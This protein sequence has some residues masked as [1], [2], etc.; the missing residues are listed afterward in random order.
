[1]ISFR[2]HIVTIV[3]VFLALAIGLLGGAAFVQPA[4]QEQLQDQTDL[5]R[6]DLANR[7]QQIE[8]LREQVAA[9]NGFAESVMPYLTSGALTGTPVVVVTQTGVEDEVLAQA[10]TALASA[11]A[12]VVTTVSATDELVSEDPT[13]QDQLATIVGEPTAPAEEL[14]TLAAEALAQGLSPSTTVIGGQVLDEL[15]S[16]GFLAPVGPGPSQVT[17]EEIGAPGQVVVV[18]SGGRGDQ[19]TL[20]PEVFAVPLVDA[21]AELD[22]PVAAGE[23]LLTDY[24]FVVDVR[25]DGVVTV[26]D[27]DQAMGGAALVLGLEKLLATGSGGAYGVKDGAEPLPPPA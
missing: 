25:S 2:Y 11:G 10:K 16:G 22:V 5:L 24:P 23:S 17:L 8:D 18:L 21:L 14:P 12:D 13:T 26:D 6:N 7:T 19:P 4:L 3:A 15:L 20:A 1:V 27:L 9:L